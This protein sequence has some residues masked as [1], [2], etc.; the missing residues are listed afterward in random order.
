MEE[1][2]DQIDKYLKSQLDQEEERIFEAAMS[3][4][5]Q[6]AQEVDILKT[7]ADSFE[8]KDVLMLEEKIT[9]IQR[10]GREGLE[11]KPR[12]KNKTIFRIII[13]LAAA[14]AIIIFFY[15]FFQPTAKK[16][17]QSPQDLYAYT[18]SKGWTV[19]PDEIFPV[20][21]NRDDK[22]MT[23]PPSLE[24]EINRAY[25][26]ENYEQ[27]V[28]LLENWQSKGDN[29][30]NKYNFYRGIAEL[31]LGNYT[32]SKEAFQL[33]DDENYYQDA[34]WNLT[35]AHLLSGDLKSATTTLKNISSDSEKIEAEELLNLIEQLQ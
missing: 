30:L 6:L 33:V 13:G 18:I 25:E 19:F 2:Y 22:G 5:N 15:I 11:I 24:E 34:Q 7:L 32:K 14:I 1:K 31:K 27:F 3:K 12:S 16:E 23:K 8:E 4:D 26:S 10:K 20:N 17:F 35:M 28:L 29:R 9:A 21:L